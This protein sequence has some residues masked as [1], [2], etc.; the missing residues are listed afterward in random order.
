MPM[1]T[2]PSTPQPPAN[3]HSAKPAEA[4]PASAGGGGFRDTLNL[5]QTAF[6]MKANLVQNEP[7]S[8]KR[9]QAMKLYERLRAPGRAN[10]RGRFV[11]HDGPP[12]ANGSIHLGHLMN[13][14]LKDFVVRSR[15]MMG[16]DCPFVPGWDC[17]GLPIEHKVMTELV[18]KGK[19]TKI[20]DLPE[21]QRRMIVRREC[22]AYAEK[23]VKLQRGQMERLLTLADYEQPYLTMQPEFEGATLEVLAALVE[24]GLVYRALKPVHW[25]IANET[26]LAEAELEYYDRQDP[27]VYVD[28][29]ALD[30]TAVYAAFGLPPDGDEP[31]T[32]TGDDAPDVPDAGTQASG[33]DTEEG[34]G[35]GAPKPGTRPRQAPCLM[36]WTTTPWTLPANLAIAVNPKFDYALVWVDGNVT[37]IAEA[38]VEKVTKL[39]GAE[40]VV[41]LARAS[42]AKLVGLRYRHPFVDAA[43]QEGVFSP[44]FAR[45]DGLADDR[46]A[47]DA[48]RVVPAEYVTLEDGTGLVHTAPGHGA[49]D[50]DTGRREGLPVYCPVRADGQYDKTVPAWLHGLDVW[51]ANDKIVTKL[52]ESGHMFHDLRFTHSYPHDW[53]SKT[54]TIYRCTEQWF[55]AVDKPAKSGVGGGAG[56]GVGAG[57]AGGDTSL[58]ALALAATG[59]GGETRFVPEWGRNR[60]RGMLES[61]PDWCISRQRAWGLPIPAFFWRGQ[62]GRDTVFMSAAT[63]KAVAKLIREKGA[64]VWFSSSA[65][66][67]LKHYDPAGEADPHARAVLAQPGFSLAGLRKG[68]DIVDV[69]F[70]S[71]STWNAVMRERGLARGGGFPIDLYLEGSDQHRGWFQSSLLPSLGV[72]GVPPFKTLLTHGF[73]VDKDG[74]KLSKSRSDAARYEV[75]NLCSEFGV[76]AMRW[77][78]SSLPYENDIKADLEFFASSGESY[79]KIRNTLRFLLS[80]LYDFTPGPAGE[81]PPPP[82]APTSL[83]A[84][85]LA[86]FAT[87][88]R[89][90]IDA[91]ERFDFR[92]AH[93][94]LYDFCNDTLSATY[95]AAVKDRLYCDRPDSARRRQCQGT[96]W[97]LCDGLCRLLAPI[98]CH[99]ADEA[100]RSLHKVA[101]GD[102]TRCV[103]LEEFAPPPAGRADAGWTAVMAARSAALAAIEKAKGELGVD[104]PLEMG[105][106][107]PDATAVGGGAGSAGGVLARFDRID[108]ADLLGVSRVTVEPGAGAVRA[109][110][111]RSEPRCERS[112]RR[113]GT[114]KARGPQG[115]ML[116]DRDAEAV[117]LA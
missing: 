1:T 6:P 63:V 60:M 71:G 69:W 25:S 23:Y 114:V 26:A 73:I 50:F 4:K 14:C 92:T 40:E 47:P 24:K 33:D 105:V 111:L 90:V 76:D 103:Q 72:M 112:W 99:T 21:D 82:P 58:R 55:V 31:E 5:P 13:K 7:A 110:D 42:G 89:E 38:L 30:A 28:F 86:E 37:V 51:K 75:E 15:T 74:K 100:Y 81:P 68:P 96:L 62:D 22:Q 12:Y 61:R 98:L 97:T 53:R 41:I 80:N 54:P 84:W 2:P 19:W 46:P 91:Y 36:I 27:S 106:T 65:E 116:S 113:D 77:W 67:L 107:L 57:V 78:V 9:W 104:N 115:A 32:A 66:E 95:F 117:G 43:R 101:P 52:R 39:G 34:G 94:K 44:E 49:E 48:F 29:E 102:L 79:R 93:Q 88:S 16:F 10:P 17:H 87:L 59:E 20:K 70:E 109:L 83:D 108:L 35:Q 8:V 11:F 45:V 56:A 3:P 64:D 18:E 85:A